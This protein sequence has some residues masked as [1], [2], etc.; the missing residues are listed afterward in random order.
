[1]TD[2]PE[3]EERRCQ[4]CSAPI[5]HD[6]IDVLCPRCLKEK[7]AGERMEAAAFAKRN[8]PPSS[9]TTVFVVIGVAVLALALLARLNNTP[10]S[11]QPA[12]A[13]ATQ[14]ATVPATP[15]SSGPKRFG[16]TEQERQDIWYRAIEAQYRAASEAKAAFGDFGPQQHRRSEALKKKYQ[17]VVR[18][19]AKLTPAQFEAIIDEGVENSWDAPPIPD[20]H[21]PETI[22]AEANERKVKKILEGA[23]RASMEVRDNYGEL[24]VHPAAWAQLPLSQKERFLTNVAWARE[25]IHGGQETEGYV[26]VKDGFTGREL[27]GCDHIW[28]PWVKE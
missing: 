26:R 27:G 3:K 16:L 13:P 24:L 8:R 4:A 14:A 23:S 7:Q 21:R 25:Q 2:E 28:G 22:I 9:H 1:M 5:D 15:S 18:K 12:P 19:Q 20:S 6:V 17:A 10:E 11:A